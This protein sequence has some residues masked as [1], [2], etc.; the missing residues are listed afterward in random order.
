QDNRARPDKFVYDPAKPVPTNGGAVCCDNNIF[1][2]GP[3]D[4][5]TVERRH[6]VLVYTTPPLTSDMEVTGP[7]KLVLFASSTA[8]DT[9]FTA[10]LVD[11][12]PGGQAR[13][14]TDGILRVRYRD[15]L[16]HPKLMAIGQVYRLNVD[17]GVT[18]NVFRAGHSIRLE[19]SSS[20]FPRFDR[21]PNTGRPVADEK[22][23]RKAV[24]TVY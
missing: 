19:I 16:E 24:Q 5:R 11:V 8:P 2:W 14:L 7:I 15:S 9:D 13:I 1:P 23:L 20:N 10:K 3:L 22:N 12:F 6:D 17:V 18:S 4:Q 21:N